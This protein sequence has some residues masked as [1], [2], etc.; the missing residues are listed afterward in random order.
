MEPQGGEKLRR[1]SGEVEFNQIH[2]GYVPEREVLCGLTLKVK[3]GQV[4]GLVGPS[5]SGKTTA[6]DLLMRLYEPNSGAILIDGQKLSGLEAA[7]VRHEIGVVAAD[8]VVFRESLADNIRYE[9]PDATMEEVRGAALAA[10][11]GNAL[12]RLPKGLQTKVGEGGIRL[13]VGEA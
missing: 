1:G 12:E 9:R 6:M 11:L 4:V 8:G 3:A 10:G 5:G 7:S 2:F 13:S